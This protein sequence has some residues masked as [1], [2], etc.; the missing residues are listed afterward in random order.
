MRPAALGARR[1]GA[2]RD[3]GQPDRRAQGGGG[4]CLPVR[5]RGRVVGGRRVDRLGPSTGPRGPGRSVRHPRRAARDHR[6]PRS[7]DGRW[8][9]RVPRVRP[10]PSRR[11]IAAPAAPPG[12]GAAVHARLLRSRAA[13]RHLGPVVVRGALVRRAVRT[14]RVTPRRVAAA[15]PRARPGS[16]HVRVR[17]VSPDSAAGQAPPR[18]IPHHRAH[19]VG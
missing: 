11:A 3:A 1:A 15:R 9:G 4:R 6:K 10:R 14:P 7:R 13:P 16:P 5:A 8:L 17:A 2:A 18:G 19:P 12:A